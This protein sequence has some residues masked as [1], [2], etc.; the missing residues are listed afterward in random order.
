MV[1][2]S[3]TQHCLFSV[4]HGSAA[5]LICTFKSQPQFTPMSQQL[6]NTSVTSW[7]LDS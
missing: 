3:L 1:C 6:S 4:S 5:H 7:C 2:M